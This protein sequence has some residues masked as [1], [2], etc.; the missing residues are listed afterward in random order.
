MSMLSFSPLKQPSPLTLPSLLSKPKSEMTQ[1]E[2][3]ELEAQEWANGPMSQLTKAVKEGTQILVSSRN[4]RKLLANVKAFDRHFNL[5]LENVRE[6]W[7]ER[8]VKRCGGGSN[9]ES[10]S[11]KK[12]KTRTPINKDRFISKMFLRGDS[13]ILIVFTGDSGNPPTLS[14]TA[15]TPSISKNVEEEEEKKVES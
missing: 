12:K 15:T 6:V 13:V 4:N 9:G 3:R 14:T 11:K 7:T 8:S 1:V 10:S 2:L 5:V